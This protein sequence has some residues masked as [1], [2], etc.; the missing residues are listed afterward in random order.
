[1]KRN[2]QFGHFCSTWNTGIALFPEP[3]SFLGILY[4]YQEDLELLN[5]YKKFFFWSE[6]EVKHSRQKRKNSFNNKVMI[7][8][9]YNS[10]T[11]ESS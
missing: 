3:V 4:F 1:M 11:R 9:N 7:V 8:L 5:T 6:K 2:G 10:K